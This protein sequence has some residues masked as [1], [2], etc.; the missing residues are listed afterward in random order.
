MSKVWLTLNSRRVWLSDS[1]LKVRW[2]EQEHSIHPAQKPCFC[3]WIV[4]N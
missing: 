4:K 1:F 3:Q 2:D